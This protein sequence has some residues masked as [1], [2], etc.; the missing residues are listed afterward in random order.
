MVADQ[1]RI[2][3]VTPRVRRRIVPIG[4]SS[5]AWDAGRKTTAFNAVRLAEV[6]SENRLPRVMRQ[7][8]MSLVVRDAF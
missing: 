3:A 7:L 1:H 2:R 6:R 5:I 8:C 4:T